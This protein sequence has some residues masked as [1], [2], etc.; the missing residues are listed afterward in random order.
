M[1]ILICLLPMLLILTSCGRNEYSRSYNY[2]SDGLIHHSKTGQLYSGK[3]IDTTDTFIMEVDVIDGKRNG[4]YKIFDLKGNKH[5][6]GTMK[7]NLNEG[8]WKYFYPNGKVESEGVFIN[9]R[10]EGRW[11]FYYPSGIKSEE[12]D[13]L[14]G[15]RNGTWIF[16]DTLGRVDSTLTLKSDSTL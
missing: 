3:I 12:G 13:F 9:D 15:A 8:A 2:G 16:Y 4:E 6:Q 7:N 11:V 14:K 5:I 1:K 10:P